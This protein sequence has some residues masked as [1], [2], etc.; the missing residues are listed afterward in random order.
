MVAS[1]CIESCFIQSITINVNYYIVTKTNG[2]SWDRIFEV[3]IGLSE[4]SWALL[5][6]TVTIPIVRGSSVNFHATI[7]KFGL[8]ALHRRRRSQK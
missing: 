5:V 4:S 7:G 1:F 3:Q 2:C 8:A 6:V